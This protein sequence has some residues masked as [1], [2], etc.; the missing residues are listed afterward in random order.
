MGTSNTNTRNAAAAINASAAGADFLDAFRARA[1]AGGTANAMT[2]AEFMGLALY[3]ER[4]GYYRRE[5]RRVG[6]G[7]DTDFFTAGTSGKIFG[8]LVAAACVELLGGADEAARHEFVEIGAEPND[9]A[10]R[11]PDVGGVLAGVAHP[12]AGAR[13]VRVGESLA[14]AGPC[15]VFSNELFDAQPL[16]RF[17]RRGGAWRELGVALRGEMLEEIEMEPVAA[18]WLPADAPEGYIFDAPRAAAE[19]ATAIAAQP[20]HGLF[21]ACDYG[22]TFAALAH[23]TPAGSV[24][25]Y[26][27]HTQSNDLLVRPG[28]QDLTGHVCWDWLAGALGEGGFAVAAV[29]SQEAFFVRHAA[30]WL[31]RAL[32]AETHSLS[33]RKR[34]LMQLLHPAQMGQKF[35]VLHARRTAGR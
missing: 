12:F 9:D 22:K 34:A 16:R 1:G 26:H 7:P 30:G 24:R 5:R 32:T 33:P 17:V 10:L 15:V 20:W 4:V 6:R 14:L 11:G 25:A 19:L 27:R 13:V 18:E 21:V 29:E 31:E 35:Q 8:E 2:F 23:E 28:E 3:D